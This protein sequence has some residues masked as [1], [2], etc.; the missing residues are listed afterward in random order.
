M[1]L[2]HLRRWVMILFFVAAYEAAATCQTVFSQPGDAKDVSF[3]NTLLSQFDSI[4]QR[5]LELRAE[6]P[7]QDQFAAALRGDLKALQEFLEHQ[8]YFSEFQQ[9]RAVLTLV[10]EESSLGTLIGKSS[11]RD[12]SL[13][14]ISRFLQLMN[15]NSSI[16]ISKDRGLVIIDPRPSG[17][18][19]AVFSDQVWRLTGYSTVIDVED[20]KSVV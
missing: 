13:L 3:A 6:T 18:P 15:I 5:L 8:E 10:S 20:R 11:H 1:F 2:S 16:E 19:L 14:L 7:K 12:S 4:V 9:L 17:H